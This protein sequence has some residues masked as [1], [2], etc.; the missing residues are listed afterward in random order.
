MFVVLTSYREDHAKPVKAFE[1]HT[2]F[3]L[4]MAVF[5]NLLLTCMIIFLVHL[6][7]NALFQ[8]GVTIPFGCGTYMTGSRYMYTT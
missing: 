6:T 2:A 3:V 1:G 7:D 8:R 4:D 5:Q